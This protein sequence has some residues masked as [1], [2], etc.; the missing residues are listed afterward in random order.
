VESAVS[1]AANEEYQLKGIMTPVKAYTVTGMM[2]SP[3][4]P[5]A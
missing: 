5:S 2:L 1:V 4:I 3:P